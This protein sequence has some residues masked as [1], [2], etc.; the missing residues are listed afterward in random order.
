MIPLGPRLA[1]R[2]AAPQKALA[3]GLIVPVEDRG[4]SHQGEVIA[5][6]DGY[7][8]RGKRLPLDVK[9]GDRVVYSTRVD[10][11]RVRGAL[12]DV[13]EEASVIKVIS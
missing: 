13:V 1:I 3:W 10:T 4:L 8:V 11:F 7:L 2:R 6:G 5:A 9:V 12:V